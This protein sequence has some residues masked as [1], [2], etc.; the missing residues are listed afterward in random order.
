[1]LLKSKHS[2]IL[3]TDVLDLLNSRNAS[4]NFGGYVCSLDGRLAYDGTHNLWEGRI[5]TGT[6]TDII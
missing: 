3:V 1:V 4:E 2:F 5:G 6:N